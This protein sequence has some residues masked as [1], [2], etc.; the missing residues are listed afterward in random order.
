MAARKESG[1]DT[2]PAVPAKAR[3]K[4]GADDRSRQTRGQARR[5]QIIEAAIEMLAARGYRGTSIAELADKVGLTHPGLLYYFGTKERL[6]EEV[7]A[8]RQ[9]T[10]MS[11]YLSTID[12]HGSVFN[13]DQVAKFVTDTAVFTR[14]YVV[15]AAENLDPGDPLHDFFVTRYD[16]AR[17]LGVGVLRQDQERGTIRSDVDVEQIGIEVLATMMGLEIQWLMD[18]EH[19]DLIGVIGRYIDGLRERLSP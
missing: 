19:V 18:P 6:L 1:A 15:L 16:L 17:Q 10:E 9:A 12:R 2:A 13:L 7:V 11:G 5:D 14:L 3:A 8:A 4:A